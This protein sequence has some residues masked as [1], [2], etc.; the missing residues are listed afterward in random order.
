MSSGADGNIIWQEAASSVGTDGHDG[1][2]ARAVVVMLSFG[3]AA[4][5]D[6]GRW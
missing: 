1:F 5:Q 3:V 2:R 6:A 4:G